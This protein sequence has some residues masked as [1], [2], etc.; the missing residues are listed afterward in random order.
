MDLERFRRD[1]AAFVRTLVNPESGR[2]FEL[3]PAQEA[4]LRELFTPGPDGRLRYSQAVFSAPKK[5]GKTTFGALVTLYTVL[6]HGGRLAEGY[7][8]ANDEEQAVSRVFAGVVN[9]VEA[10]PWLRALAKVTNGEVSFPATGSKIVAQAAEYAG[11]AGANPTITVVD[12]LWAYVTERSKRLWDETPPVPTRAV[13]LRLVVSYAGFEDEPGPLRELYDRGMGG[14][15]VSDRW[16]MYRDGDLL[17]FWSHEPIAPWQTL[18]WIESMRRT[19]RP[20]AFARLIENRWVSGTETPFIPIEWWDQA[21][22]WSPLPL[23]PEMPVVLGV[24]LGL[25]HD[26]AAVVATT[27]DEPSARVYLVGSRVFVPTGDALDIEATVEAAILDFASRFRV[28]EARYDPWQM[29]RSAQELARAGVPMVEFPQ[30]SDR[31][32]RATVALWEL[33][34][35][36]RLVAYPD[37]AMRAALLRAVAKETPRGVRLAKEKAGHRIDPAVALAISALGTLE[38]FGAGAPVEL[39][40]DAHDGLTYDLNTGRVVAVD[41]DRHQKPWIPVGE[42]RIALEPDEAGPT[43]PGLDDGRV[44]ITPF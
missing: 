36:K 22:Q 21:P 7:V 24:D 1:P 17:V 3:L 37:G 44:R 43:L 38:V 18:A 10:T 41:P 12:E 34:R 26:S 19:L 16:P 6:V 31:L 25:K 32:S 9:I 4:F 20:S 33:L 13:S 2:P 28:V 15:R 30:T 11:A 8:F 27:W 35:D 14:E 23:A 5:S 40:Y 42:S 29:Q 39:V